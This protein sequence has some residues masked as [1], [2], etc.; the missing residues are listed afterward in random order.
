[1]KALLIIAAIVTV[2]VL[3][4]SPKPEA[5]KCVHDTITAQDFCGRSEIT[6]WCRDHNNAAGDLYDVVALIGS[7]NKDRT[8]TDSDNNKKICKGT[9]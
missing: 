1:M 6:S 3:I 8:A 9:N 7:H 5:P 4:P 2:I